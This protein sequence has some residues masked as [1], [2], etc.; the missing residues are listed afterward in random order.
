ME[1]I[2][3]FYGSDTGS[4]EVVKDLIVKE[5]G[6]EFVHEIDAYQIKVSDF[7]DFDKIIIGLS[8]WYDGD[9]QSD[10]ESFFEDF[11]TIDFTGKKVAIFGLGDQY[12][13]AE[14]FVDGIGILGEVILANG[15]ELF[16]V[17]PTA[18][19]D[20]EESKAEFQQGWFMGLAVDE[21]NQRELTPERV[22]VWVNQVLEEFEFVREEFA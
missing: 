10:W 6:K 13:Y 2:G 18:G 1:K 8:T 19:Y 5:I 20:Y 7:K 17:W 15:G 3:V 11:Q 9:L 4:T 21:D 16:G 22:K 12:G 14:Y